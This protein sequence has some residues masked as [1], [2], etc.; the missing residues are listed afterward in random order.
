MDRSISRSE[1]RR[2]RHER[3]QAAMREAGID[4]SLASSIGQPQCASDGSFFAPP[5]TL[6]AVRNSRR[7]R[8]LTAAAELGVDVPADFSVLDRTSSHTSQASIRRQ[9]LRREHEIMQKLETEQRQREREELA[10]ER[11]A[12]RAHAKAKRE[13]LKRAR[14]REGL[15]GNPGSVWRRLTCWC[16]SVALQRG[17]ALR[18]QEAE[19]DEGADEPLKQELYRV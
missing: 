2:S 16:T 6:K 17:R 1:L 18:P 5:T 12:E 11:A 14:E 19:Q 15:A 9:R 13:Y 8:E 10:L 3:E 7:R 4:P